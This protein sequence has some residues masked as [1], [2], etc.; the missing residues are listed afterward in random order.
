MDTCTCSISKHINKCVLI[1]CTKFGAG[2]TEFLSYLVDFSSAIKDGNLTGKKKNYIKLSFI[3]ERNDFND[4]EAK[5]IKAN[6]KR[7]L[8]K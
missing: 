3:E 8:E 7:K 4:H 5:T 6:V 2:L 1:K